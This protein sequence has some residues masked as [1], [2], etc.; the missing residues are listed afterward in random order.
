ML[1]LEYPKCS[2]CKKAKKWLESNNIS[3]EQRDI[4]KQN[5]NKEELEAWHKKSGLPLKRF[6]IQVVMSIK[7]LV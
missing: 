2:T 4:T 1:Y 3:F 5:P 7:N 6:L